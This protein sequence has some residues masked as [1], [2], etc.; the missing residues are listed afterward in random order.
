MPT[1]NNITTENKIFYILALFGYFIILAVLLVYYFTEKNLSNYVHYSNC[2]SPVS[3]Y[4]VEAGKSSDSILTSC[5]S[6]KNSLCCHKATDLPNAINFVQ[7]NEGIK[8]SYNEKTKNVC[9]LDPLNTK[10][11]NN[12]QSSIYTMNRH[13]IKQDA[14]G[15][16]K[17]EIKS[18]FDT[19]PAQNSINIKNLN[20]T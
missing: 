8:F 7:L 10:Y 12:P 11:N 19:S 16:T 14:E 1:F 6:Q 17:K 13:N 5:G 15:A 4:S 9:I 3:D 20:L 18:N 2:Y